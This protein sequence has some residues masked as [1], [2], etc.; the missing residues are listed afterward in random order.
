[1]S[2]RDGL[3]G[4]V[5]IV[6]LLPPLLDSPLQEWLSWSQPGGTTQENFALLLLAASEAHGQTDPGRYRTPHKA[7][8]IGAS[9]VASG[10]GRP[11]RRVASVAALAFR[12][13]LASVAWL[14]RSDWMEGEDVAFEVLDE[15]VGF[16]TFR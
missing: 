10:A 8:R 7:E 16:A 14:S 3:F 4:V 9:W 6:V 2:P 1:V 15:A 13:T 11:P 12:Y 5:H